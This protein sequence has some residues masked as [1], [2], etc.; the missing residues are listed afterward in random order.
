MRTRQLLNIHLDFT[1]VICRHDIAIMS[2]VLDPY[3]FRV[4][5]TLSHVLNSTS[6]CEL[7]TKQSLVV[8]TYVRPYNYFSTSDHRHRFT[9]LVFPS[10][11]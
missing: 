7:F 9:A 4:V 5:F 2:A 1:H 6:S 8:R 10:V 11:E 3:G